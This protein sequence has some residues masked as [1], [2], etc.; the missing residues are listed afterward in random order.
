MYPTFCDKDRAQVMGFRRTVS[1]NATNGN[2]LGEPVRCGECNG[3]VLL[4]NM[5]V[6]LR[7]RGQSAHSPSFGA[8]RMGVSGLKGPGRSECICS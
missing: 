6:P 2:V 8:E 4:P 1:L 3:L 5:S 7:A